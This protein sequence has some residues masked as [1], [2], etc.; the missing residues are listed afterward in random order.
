MRWVGT[1]ERTL[2]RRRSACPLTD[3]PSDT[4]P[5]FSADGSLITFVP[6]GPIYVIGVDGSGL[7]R[8]DGKAAEGDATFSPNGESP[9]WGP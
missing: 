6:A 7:R 1:N 8:V 9:A 3:D 2:P 4:S 5:S